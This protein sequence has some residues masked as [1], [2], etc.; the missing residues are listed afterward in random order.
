M[1]TSR[2]LSLIVILSA[3]GG[4]S[5]VPIGHLGN[6]LK[7]VPGAPLGSSQ[8]LSGLHVLWIVLAA[9][10]VR[11]RGSGAMT[12]VVKGLVEA[13]LLSFHGIFVILIASLQGVIVDLVFIA[14]RR[15]NTRSICLAGGLSSAS[16]VIV[17]Q[18]ILVPGLP[19]PVLAFMYLA[20][21]I[22]GALLAGYL[23]KRVLDVFS[24][25]LSM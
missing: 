10:L 6:L 16:N 19:I 15:V 25:D 5:S 22:S 9:M 18:F 17:V 24:S 21:F 23:C 12:G 7:T 14:F 11:R 13:S 4:M 3:L 20:S 1:F 8:A 2:E